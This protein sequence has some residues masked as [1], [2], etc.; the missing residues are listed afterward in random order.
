MQKSN[1][2]KAGVAIFVSDKVD[3]RAKKITRE[4]ECYEYNQYN[5]NYKNVRPTR[6]IVALNVHE[7][8]NRAEKYVN[9]NIKLKDWIRKCTIKIGNLKTSQLAINRKIGLKINKDKK[10]LNHNHTTVATQYYRKLYSSTE[11]MFC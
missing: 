7:S 9:K 11:Y 5:I 6:N 10:E 8:N 2:K 3:L 1:T 4:K